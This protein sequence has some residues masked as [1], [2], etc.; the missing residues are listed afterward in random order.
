MQKTIAKTKA[1]FFEPALI[2]KIFLFDIFSKIG[3]TESAVTAPHKIP[4]IKDWTMK[5]DKMIK[6][7]AKIK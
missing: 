4:N 6:K 3:Q 2:K 7:S 5:N 1:W